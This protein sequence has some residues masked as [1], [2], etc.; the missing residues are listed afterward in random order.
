MLDRLVL[1]VIEL[2]LTT[3]VLIGILLLLVP[4]LQKRYRVQWR[5]VAWIALAFRLLIPFNFTLPLLPIEIKLPESNVKVVA[6]QSTPIQDAVLQEA[7]QP[8]PET[9]YLIEATANL[10]NVPQL[11]SDIPKP[12][13]PKSTA[14]PQFTTSLLGII[15]SIW[16]FGLCVFLLFQV[17]TYQIFLWKLSASDQENIP[18]LIQ[19]ALWKIGMNMGI[20]RLPKPHITN[21]VSAPVLIGI[22][23]PRILLPHADYS[24]EEI[25]FILRHELSHYR[26]KD[27]WYKLILLLANA[28]H[29]FNPLIYFMTAQAARDIE[30]MCDYDVAKNFNNNERTQY[31]TTILSALPR[32][33]GFSTMFSTQF[34][35][36]KQNIKNRLRN[37]FDVH[38]KRRGIV[39]L[40]ALMLCTLFGT[41]MVTFA[42][43]ASTTAQVQ[44]E[45]VKDLLVSAKADGGT[46]ASATS[47]EGNTWEEQMMAEIKWLDEIYN[48]EKS[49][50]VI[51]E[52]LPITEATN[53]ARLDYLYQNSE[54][55]RSMSQM[56]NGIF[57][58]ENGQNFGSFGSF[59]EEGMMQRIA[60]MSDDDE[61]I[62]LDINYSLS[63]GRM[64]V[65]LVD[66]SGKI[67]YEGVQATS[68]KN[69]LSYPG[70]KGLWSVLI[71][72][73]SKSQ[74]LKGNSSISL[75]SSG[76]KQQNIQASQTPSDA[77]FSIERLGRYSFE[78]GDFFNADLEWNGNG[79]VILLCTKNNLNDDE[80]K[81]QLQSLSDISEPDESKVD[82]SK[83][84]GL[85]L[86]VQS[87]KTPLHSN[88]KIN[89]SASYYSYLI[90][91]NSPGLV[92][93]E[94]TIQK[95]NGTNDTVWS[96]AKES[97]TAN[98]TDTKPYFQITNNNGNNVAHSGSF[99]A[100]S[101]Q[102]LTISS[103]SSIKG[104]TVD[105]FLFSPSGKEQ[106][107]SFGGSDISQTVELTEGTWAYNTSGIFKSGD[108]VITC[109]VQ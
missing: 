48:A 107:I 18:E 54:V 40:C 9:E 95:P 93:G 97:A 39:T 100:K 64:A 17:G 24:V 89:D 49:E 104:G 82:L 85:M 78:K 92:T 14:K 29:W 87:V 26:R 73:D 51:K 41:G 83:L 60:V 3:S 5:Y 106:R 90:R 109:S 50:F 62:S 77:H 75:I 15:G 36:S 44:L 21:A 43:A 98:T 108:I 56:K 42:Y 79:N 20:D 94:V 27:M 57:Q 76:A 91:I 1:Q 31:A 66:P 19:E 84:G 13:L 35:S 86:F 96:Q 30:S 55:F 22:L 105:L 23:N 61:P 103:T 16:I 70:A 8:Q 11:I 74:A 59:Y 10:E 68:Y 32:K 2:S 38:N 37:L 88:L 53:T 6:P 45:A 99:I 28:I 67:V 4:F 47:I 7:I 81:K 33:R 25:H 71:I 69:E 101:G 63:E 46:W 80:I 102:V 52:T 34:G 58:V 72:A 12:I 65:W